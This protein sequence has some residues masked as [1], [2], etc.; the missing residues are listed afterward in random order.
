MVPSRATRNRRCELGVS[1]ILYSEYTPR[2]SQ[3]DRA[4]S[5]G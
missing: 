2:V 3:R 4:E 5:H 1:P